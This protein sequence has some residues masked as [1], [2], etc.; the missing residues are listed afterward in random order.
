ML[1]KVASQLTK[2]L[3][4]HQA[5]D[6]KNYETIKYGIMLIISSVNCMLSIL[7]ISLFANCLLEGIIFLFFFMTLRTKCG[8]YHCSSYL[9]CWLFTNL[10]FI[11]YL[12]L[13]KCSYFEGNYI[14]ILI[15]LG[16]SVFTIYKFAPIINNNNPKTKNQIEK[17]KVVARMTIIIYTALLI[18][19]LLMFENII[20]YYTYSAVLAICMVIFLMYY[21][22]LVDWGCKYVRKIS[23]S[24]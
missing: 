20:L 23:K 10:I 13:I 6:E 11:I 12:M 24:N 1:D 19:F 17:K 3:I 14:V 8:G 5:T 18:I 21:E 2:W 15:L 4:K 7:V 16:F 22:F 9:R